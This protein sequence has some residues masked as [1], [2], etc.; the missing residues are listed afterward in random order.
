M[1]LKFFIFT[2]IRRYT[3]QFRLSEPVGQETVYI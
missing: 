1:D 3:V 2:V